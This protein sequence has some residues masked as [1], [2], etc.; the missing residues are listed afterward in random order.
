MKPILNFEK[1]KFLASQLGDPSCIPDFIGSH[2]T[3]NSLHF[4]LDERD[5]IYEGYGKIK[6]SYPYR[7]YTTYNRSLTQVEYRV[8]S[9]ENDYIYAEFLPELGGRLWTLIDKSTGENLLYTNDVIR[10]SNLAVRNAWFSGG[11]EWNIGVIGHSPFT[12][13][14]LYT[15]QLKDE[16]GTPILRMYEYERIRNVEYQ[17]DF[18]LGEEDHFLNCCMRIVN[19]SKEVVP[20]YWWSNMAVPEYDHGRIIVPAGEAFTS[21]GKEVY[22][23]A[24]PMVNDVDISYYQDIPKQVDY[25]FHIPENAPKYIMNINDS[26]YGLLHISTDRLKSRKLFSWGNNDGSDRWQEYLTKDAGRYVEIQAGLGKTQYGCIPMAPHTAWEWMEQYGPV[27]FKPEDIAQEFSSLRVLADDYVNQEMQNRDLSGTFMTHQ[28]LLQNSASLIQEGSP[29]GVLEAL[30]RKAAHARPLSSHLTY[31]MEP[32]QE[33][34]WTTFIK[35]GELPIPTINKVPVDYIADEKSYRLL[36][37]SIDKVNQ[38]N[39]YAHYLLGAYYLWKRRDL[40]AKKELLASIR[41]QDNPWAY[42]ALAALSLLNNK[43][44]DAVTYVEKGLTYQRDN[45]SYLI[46]SFRILLACEEYESLVKIYVNLSRDLKENTRLTFGYITSLTRTGHE[47]QAYKLLSDD[48][49]LDDLREC[50]DTLG[51]IWKEVT[52]KLFGKAQSVPHELNFESL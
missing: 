26:G 8:A 20:M 31:Q 30:N 13:E 11:V 25:F 12:T 48:F 10:F 5:E 41:L 42:A 9:L 44:K 40:A 33:R 17:M 23:T 52:E 24:V 19:S 6:T 7:H 2:M 36:R 28:S 4:H 51:T 16:D 35:T 43:N 15:A 32:K 45:L 3:D 39:W 34:M 1:K 29:Y 14:P 18:W 47:K 37:D 27:Q 21:Q 50:D 22:K 49:V 46:E 38:D